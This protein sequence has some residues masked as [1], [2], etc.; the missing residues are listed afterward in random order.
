M[1]TTRRFAELMALLLVFCALG[2]RTHAFY[3]QTETAASQ[4][5]QANTCARPIDTSDWKTY[6]DEKHGFELSYPPAWRVHTSSGA[7][8][9]IISIDKAAIG[10]EPRASLTFA[11]QQERNPRKHGIEQWFA[12]ELQAM[13]ATPALSGT[14]NIAGQPAIFTENTNSFGTT[15]SVFTLLHEIDVLSVSYPAQEQFDSTYAAIVN[16]LR[17]LK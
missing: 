8:P 17:I 2:T 6:R 16:S 12:E 14:L 9:E 11:V 1:I 10:G 5:T 15:H 3:P 4:R 13:K 7:G